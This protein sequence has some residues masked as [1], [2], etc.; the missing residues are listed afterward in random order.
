MRHNWVDANGDYTQM[1]LAIASEAAKDPEMVAW[2]KRIQTNPQ[3]IKRTE[4]LAAECADALG[5]Y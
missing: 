4:R 2:A 1:A 5:W 3:N